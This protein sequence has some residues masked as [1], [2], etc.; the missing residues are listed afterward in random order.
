[1]KVFE[2]KWDGVKVYIREDD[3]GRATGKARRI[4]KDRGFNVRYMNVLAFVNEV[5]DAGQ[6]DGLV[7]R[8]EAKVL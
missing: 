6:V 1:M 4:Y 2:F 7:D 3:L 8:S 5:P